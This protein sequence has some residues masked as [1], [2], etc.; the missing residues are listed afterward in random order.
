MN[1]HSS[2]KKKTVDSKSPYAISSFADLIYEQLLDKYVNQYKEL[3]ILCIGSDRSTGDALGPLV[4]YKLEPIISLYKDTYV[5]GTLEEPVHAKNLKEKID[6]IYK[7]F[8]KPFVIAIDASLGRVDRIG[9]LNI[10]DGPLS[11]GLG[12]NKILPKIGNISITGIVNVGGVME[13]VVLQN[14]R[15]SLVMKMAE[16]I[17][18]SIHISL[19]KIIKSEEGK[20]IS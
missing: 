20:D 1:L 11:P 2:V 7:N 6:Y 19:L 4:G 3:V 10:K 17:S 13:Y 16:I 8:S 12:V 9:Y 5:L 14:T 15:L 18:K